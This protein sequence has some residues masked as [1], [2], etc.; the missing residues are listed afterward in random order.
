MMVADLRLILADGTLSGQVHRQNMY[1]EVHQQ[2]C[3]HRISGMS[4]PSFLVLFSSL[5]SWACQ[6]FV[7][8]NLSST[9]DKQTVIKTY[10]DTDYIFL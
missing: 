4:H 7:S 2:P 5:H 3:I 1:K 6:P 10:D 9:P 8:L